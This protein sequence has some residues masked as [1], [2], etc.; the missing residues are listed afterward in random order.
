MAYRGTSGLAFGVV[1]G[2][3][4]AVVTGWQVWSG[5]DNGLPPYHVLR[6]ASGRL[7]QIEMR[8]GD[9]FLILAGQRR[10]FD[11]LSKAG[12]FGSVEDALVPGQQITLWIDP[13]DI[14]RTPTIYQLEVNGR[15]L[16]SYADVRDAWRSDN[17]MAIYLFIAS[18]LGTPYL[19]FCLWRAAGR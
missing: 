12:D 17:R 9:V 2:V 10:R 3:F 11:Y 4:L 18:F 13:A 15:M 19:V 1:C 5:L 14:D 7:V 8:R 6:D 16:R